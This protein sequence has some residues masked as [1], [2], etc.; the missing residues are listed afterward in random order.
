MSDA[1]P[2]RGRPE[3]GEYATPEEQ[4][5]AIKQPAEWQLEGFE[6]DAA[7][8]Q[9]ASG[10]YRPGDTRYPPFSDPRQS[11]GQPPQPQPGVR[12]PQEE[13][14]APQQPARAGAGDR[15]VTFLLLAFGLSNVI[16]VVSDA[17]NGGRVMRE[18]MTVMGG[19]Y[20][21]LADALPT[22][23]WQGQAIIYGAVWLVTLIV[24]LSAMRA[25]RR[26]WWV[27]LVGAFVAFILFFAIFVIALGENP[28]LMNM[29]PSP[30]PAATDSSS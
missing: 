11:P 7:P 17:F 13:S 8:A 1:E 30:T 3:Y 27:P 21:Q 4:R 26:S 6:T 28:Q 10:S 24:S 14:R 16:G 18:S 15:F 20:G 12:W 25:G 5:A 2:R 9:P 22:W 29:L 23:L 19:S